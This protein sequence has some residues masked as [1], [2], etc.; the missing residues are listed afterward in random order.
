MAQALGWGGCGV[1]SDEISALPE[2]SSAC[3]RAEAWRYALFF[4]TS[5]SGNR[6]I[7]VK[8]GLGDRG[9]E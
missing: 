5:W 1:E 8:Q 7:D 9:T 2:M 6:H 4:P 3:R